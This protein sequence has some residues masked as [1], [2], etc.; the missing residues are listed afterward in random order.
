VSECEREKTDVEN[1][2][3]L[4]PNS[5]L[6]N[7]VSMLETWKNIISYIRLIP[8][9]QQCVHDEALGNVSWKPHVH[10][11]IYVCMYVYIYIY[12]HTHIYTYIHIY[13]H[14]YAYIYIYIVS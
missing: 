10:T 13:I 8:C 6:E 7:Y 3:Y 9:P 11:Y 4:V 5:V 1:A 14:T 12:T 2:V